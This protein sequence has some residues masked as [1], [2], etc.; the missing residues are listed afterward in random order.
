MVKDLDSK[1]PTNKGVLIT[2]GLTNTAVLRACYHEPTGG[3][4]QQTDAH[5]RSPK[6]TPNSYG[7]LRSGAEPVTEST[8]VRA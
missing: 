3:R 1:A 5:D 8:R 6:A 7:R 2:P 4:S